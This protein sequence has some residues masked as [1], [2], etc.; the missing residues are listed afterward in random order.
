MSDIGLDLNLNLK[1]KVRIRVLFDI[2]KNLCISFDF[3]ENI[4]DTLYKGIVERQILSSVYAY[5]LDD[6]NKAVGMVRF[7]IDWEKHFMYAT[8]DTGKEIEIRDDI[9]LVDQFANWSR[10]LISY[11]KEMQ[12]A[13]NVKK[14]QV[15]YRYRDEIRM[16]SIKDSQAD[17]FLG[18]R[19]SN[20]KIEFAESKKLEFERSMKFV[21]EM[22]PELEIELKSNC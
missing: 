18:L 6:E 14:I 21:S 1:I 10:D 5:Y 12:K 20:K 22:L 4:V 8:T 15:Y 19:K 16:D 2:I 11:V 9:P 17:K 7:N 13:L 3:P